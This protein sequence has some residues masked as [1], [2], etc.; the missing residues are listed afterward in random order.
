M[1]PYQLTFQTWNKV[2]ALYQEKFMDLHLYDDTYDRFLEMVKKE[3][4][5]VFEIG[6]GPGNITRYLLAKRPDLHIDAIDV[7]P[8]MIE[9][10]RENVP[11]ASFE[12]R[13]CRD[14][15]KLENTYDAIMCGFALPYLSRQ[16]CA[17]L[18]KDC[19]HLLNPGGVAYFSSLE[20]DYAQS[21]YEAASTGDT[22]YVYYHEEKY[23]RQQLEAAA[24]NVKAV[25]RKQT[26]KG[27]GTSN[28][29]ILIVRKD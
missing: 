14:L 26:P 23:L 21:G 18:F 17:K 19:A 10:A 24:L 22:A 15:D 12:V 9:L 7:A 8:N 3:N 6:C 20:G 1:D 29:L 13:D 27:E 28:E 11:Q 5:T 16:D 2:A 25:M 4:A